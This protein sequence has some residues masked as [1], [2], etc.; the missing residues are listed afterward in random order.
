MLLASACCWLLIKKQKLAK[1]KQ[2]KALSQTGTGSN[3][4]HPFHTRWKM[5]NKCW[6]FPMRRPPSTT[7]ILSAGPSQLG[8]IA[9]RSARDLRVT[10]GRR[11]RK[12]RRAQAAQASLKTKPQQTQETNGT[13]MGSLTASFWSSAED[14]LWP[15][16]MP[17]LGSLSETIDYQYIMNSS[18]SWNVTNYRN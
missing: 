8:C 7:Q 5:L 6:I 9:S 10:Y 12:T 3:Q 13:V 11:D 1:I 4:E 16:I 14:G 17:V 15:Q 18:S 2:A